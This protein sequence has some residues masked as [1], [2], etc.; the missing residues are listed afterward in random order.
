M[1][2]P[3]TRALALAAAGLATVAT[4]A[5]VPV[6]SSASP[7]P[8][9]QTITFQEPR[10]QLAED[11]LPPKSKSKL[12]LGDRLAI[13][14]VLENATRA[15]VGTFGGSCTVIGTGTSVVTTPLQCEAIYRLADGQIEAMGMMTL[16]K[17]DLVIVGG[18][19]AYDGV[20][21]TVGPGKIEKGFE[22]A[23]ALTI[24]R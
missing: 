9:T 8:T 24:E 1:N 7:T 16:S 11:D 23:D 12:S 15:R 10:P 4:A 13:G 14:G 2:R 20:H 19:G 18:A 17:T 22:D 21:G 3:S 5:A 6:L